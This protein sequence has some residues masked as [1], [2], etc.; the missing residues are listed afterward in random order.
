[1]RQMNIFIQVAAMIVVSS[2]HNTGACTVHLGQL[3]LADICSYFAPGLFIQILKS[4]F[5]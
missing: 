5:S 4:V 3:R 1:M 2:R